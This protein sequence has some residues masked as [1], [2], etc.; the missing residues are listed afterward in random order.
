MKITDALYT[1]KYNPFLCGQYI[2]AFY[3]S[4]NGVEENLLLSKLVIPLST[5]PIYKH[6]LARAKFGDTKRSNLWSIFND[7]ALLYDLQERI[8]SLSDLTDKS[9]QYCLIND[10]VEI[11]PETLSVISSESFKS[12]KACKP[13]YNL[14]RLFS[15]F[16]PSEIYS[17]FGA[18]P[19]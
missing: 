1:L 5:H 13:S 15:Q 18:T 19:K 8:D 4:L 17:F 12:T 2:S 16:S 7:R 11:D 6:S 14:G 10:W 3:S 9:I